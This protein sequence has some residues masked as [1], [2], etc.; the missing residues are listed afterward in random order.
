MT[1]LYLLGI[2]A[3]IVM[4]LV[5]KN[6][7]FK[8]EAVPFVMELP[9]YRLP[10]ERLQWDIDAILSTGIE[11]KTDYDVNDEANIK[12]TTPIDLTLAEAILQA[13]ENGI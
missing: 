2:A 1:G 9:N 4:A 7:L 12:I 13:R 10:R 6:T 5:F 3:G 11:V 8:G